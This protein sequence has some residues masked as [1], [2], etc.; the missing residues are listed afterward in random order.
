M[1]HF[2]KSLGR[3]FLFQRVLL[4]EL[5]KTWLLVRPQKMLRT[6]TDYLIFFLKIWS[7]KCKQNLDKKIQT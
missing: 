3:K 4:Q 7:Y 5:T 6:P 2:R 1:L